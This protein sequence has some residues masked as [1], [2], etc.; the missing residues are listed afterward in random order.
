[1]FLKVFLKTIK[2][3]ALTIKHIFKG[4]WWLVNPAKPRE[5][6]KRYTQKILK[7]VGKIARLIQ[8]W[9]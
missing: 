4:F 8:I 9:R 5:T 2:I 3:L 6:K 1:M 7:A